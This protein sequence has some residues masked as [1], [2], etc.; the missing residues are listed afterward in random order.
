YRLGLRDALPQFGITELAM[1]F[2]NLQGLDPRGALVHLLGT[3]AAAVR[4][5]PTA[6]DWAASVCQTL[7]ST[8]IPEGQSQSN[9]QLALPV[10]DQLF[11][12][13]VGLVPELICALDT[14]IY[15]C[16]DGDAS[17]GGAAQPAC[18]NMPPPL[19]LGQGP[20]PA[21]CPG[22]ACCMHCGSQQPCGSGCISPE[23]TCGE[24]PGC[25]CK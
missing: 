5:D 15:G 19:T 17:D 16:M 1:L 7:F 23:A 13:A 22:N 3:V 4:A 10:I 20:A 12:P 11:Q 6:V 9:A 21:M 25:A 18:A 8:A 14:L 2:D 24:Q